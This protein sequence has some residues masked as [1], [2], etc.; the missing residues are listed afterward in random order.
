VYVD[1]N[2]DGLLD[3]HARVCQETIGQPDRF[4]GIRTS[5]YLRRNRRKNQSRLGLL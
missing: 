1:G 5:R 3:E 2:L 4:D